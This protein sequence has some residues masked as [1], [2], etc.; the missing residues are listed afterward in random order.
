MCIYRAYE[1]LKSDHD[2]DRIRLTQQIKALEEK[3]LE[4][5]KEMIALRT[6]NH[7]LQMNS[8]SLDKMVK[9]EVF[10][11]HCFSQPILKIN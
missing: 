6:E 1:E 4:Y 2:S 11:Y 9:Y 10:F 7:E 8:K 3:R 5:D